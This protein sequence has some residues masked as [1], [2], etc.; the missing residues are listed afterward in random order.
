MPVFSIRGTFSIR[1]KGL[2]FIIYIYIVEP[3]GFSERILSLNSS[4][5]GLPE[6]LALGMLRKNCKAAIQDAFENMMKVVAQQED[7]ES[8]EISFSVDAVRCV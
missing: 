3:C 1:R 6:S 5:I 2:L 8:Y 4:S 7:C